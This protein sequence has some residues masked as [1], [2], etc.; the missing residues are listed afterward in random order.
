MKKLI[1]GEV[2]FVWF[3]ALLCAAFLL[4]LYFYNP[5]WLVGIGGFFI[6]VIALPWLFTRWWNARLDRLVQ[7]HYHED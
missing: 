4:Y 3:I 5:I 2:A 7:K 6:V 1:W